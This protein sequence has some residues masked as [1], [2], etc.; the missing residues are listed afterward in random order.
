MT[1]KTFKQ[2]LPLTFSFVVA[3]GVAHLEANAADTPFVSIRS[4]TADHSYTDHGTSIKAWLIT[5]ISNQKMRVVFYKN[6]VFRIWL[7]DGGTGDFAEPD[8]DVLLFEPQNYGSNPNVTLLDAGTHWVFAAPDLKLKLEKVTAIFEMEKNG[9]SI[10]K[11]S[12][13]LKYSSA[14]VTQSLATN[15][16]E[17]FFGCG[18][19]MGYFSHKGRRVQ[20]SRSGWEEGSV[21]N[22]VSFYMSTK[23]YGV[24]RNTY[25]AG[26]YDF[27]NNEVIETTHN[28]NR[29]DAF[30]FVGSYGDMLDRYTELTGRP[31]LIPK[32]GIGFGDASAYRQET[33]TTALGGN[34]KNPNNQSPD[35]DPSAGMWHPHLAT[36]RVGIDVKKDY[37]DHKMP[38]A[39]MLP[40]DGYGCEYNSWTHPGGSLAVAL[41]GGK[42]DDSTGKDGASRL[43]FDVP[44]LKQFG[45]RL[46]LWIGEPSRYTPT[47]GYQHDFDGETLRQVQTAGVRLYKIDVAWSSRMDLKEDIT[48]IFSRLMNNIKENSRT[49]ANPAG[50]RG[51][52]ITVYGA[53]GSQRH[54][55]IW[56]GDQSGDDEYIRYHIPSFTGAGMSGFPYST[57]DQASIYNDFPGVYTRDIQMK[58]LM[59]MNYAMNNWGGVL[60]GI[61]TSIKRP[62]GTTG[63]NQRGKRPNI[64]ADR[65]TPAEIEINRNYLMLNRQLIPYIYSYARHSYDCGAPIVRPLVYN[66]PEDAYTFDN[67]TQYQYMTGDW[68]MA[69]PVFDRQATERDNIYLPGGRW[70]DY[71]TGKEYFGPSNISVNAPMDT[72]PIFVRAGAIIPMQLPSVFDGQKT[73]DGHWNSQDVYGGG[74]I[75]VD[76]GRLVLDIYPE[77]TTTFDLYE[78][79]G[80]T[81]NYTA[82]N[83]G[84]YAVTKISSHAPEAGKSDSLKITIGAALGNG[85]EGQRANRANQLS[86]HT[87]TLPATVRV[88]G[89]ILRKLGKKEEVVSAPGGGWFFDP[90][91]GGILTVKTEVR[92]VNTETVILVDRF[93]TPSAPVYKLALELP[94]DVRIVSKTHNSLEIGWNPDADATYYE[95]EI[96]GASPVRIDATHEALIKHNLTGLKPESDYTFR[97]RAFNASQRSGWT[98][99]IRARTAENPDRYKIPLAAANLLWA[100]GRQAGNALAFAVDPNPNTFFSTR[101]VNNSEDFDA[102]LGGMYMINKFRYAPRHNYG[103]GTVQSFQLWTSL[104]GK[105]WAQL[106]G[107]LSVTT[108]KS[109]HPDEN[110]PH[111]GDSFTAAQNLAAGENFTRSRYDYSTT[112]E[113][114]PVFA[115]YVRFVKVT[116]I[117][118]SFAVS[119]FSV[120]RSEKDISMKSLTTGKTITASSRW[121]SKDIILEPLMNYTASADNFAT[122]GGHFGYH[123]ANSDNYDWYSTTLFGNKLP[124]EVLISLPD[125]KL[126]HGVNYA[127]PTHKGAE[128]RVSKFAV[129]VTTPE[130]E[131]IWMAGGEWPADGNEHSVRF[132]PIRAKAV[133]FVAIEGS[134]ES[135]NSGGS[136]AG[137][138]RIQPLAEP[139]AN[140]VNTKRERTPAYLA[141]EPAF[142]PEH[143]IDGSA[144]TGWSSTAE[145]ADQ[146]LTVD[147]G[148]AS[149]VDYGSIVFGNEKPKGFVVEL[150]TTGSAWSK[151]FSQAENS[152]NSVFLSFAKQP[153]RY[154][155]LTLSGNANGYTVREFDLY[156]DS[157]VASIAINQSS[158]SM[159]T[160]DELSLTPVVLPESVRNRTVLW[161]SSDDAVL[162]VNSRGVLTALK[163]GVATVTARADADNAKAVTC[164]VT[165]R[166]V[167]VSGLTLDITNATLELG[168]KTQLMASAAPDNATNQGVVWSVANGKIASVTPE[169]FVATL[170][171]GKTTIRATSAADKTK[172]AECE[173]VVI[174]PVRRR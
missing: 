128:G 137:A 74:G 69:A 124:A 63:G 106:T 88:G 85:Y 20:I 160:G 82:A 150:S 119:D 136:I 53:A 1:T 121:A 55:T 172:F 112:V 167:P 102:Y 38:I 44:G 79:D 100:T 141:P 35:T 142:R 135:G 31:S 147:L 155:R 96:N 11:E 26:T 133:H 92:P 3:N 153:A 71:W 145:Q 8:S 173:I 107:P 49:E 5:S 99:L 75:A 23:G 156:G 70:I 131:R 90:D 89:T 45:T 9:A 132:R 41:N 157:P 166:D 54:T 77:G 139:S 159:F 97:V 12:T 98:S 46:G 162:K 22:P 61:E 93:S 72:M 103:N 113:F 109:G 29:F 37:I 40:N 122:D 161:D 21:P 43:G 65:F 143:S 19:Q 10:W 68:L 30:Y 52:L 16:S 111:P 56:S 17:H 101:A 6:D 81:L 110:W 126:I 24:L 50:E 164:A 127:P 57:S 134:D 14:A 60:D 25:S 149:E 39:W 165:V 78:D 58:S 170:N 94:K 91:K 64:T 15:A 105:N 158:A 66:Y 76:D 33:D 47:F 120:W 123:A 152:D 73:L 115:R 163:A 140:A 87:S 27:R 4:V 59:P 108:R 144:E 104:D 83:G 129:Y 42:A 48:N 146:V 154:V 80:Y 2:F 34:P 67:R 36:N 95:L 125:S 168:E 84:K 32:W 13:S 169:G 117:G 28:N 51:M 118:N 86:I 138:K 171:T 130:D 116:S 114:E 148:S 18:M 7:A 62:G 151:V 174:K